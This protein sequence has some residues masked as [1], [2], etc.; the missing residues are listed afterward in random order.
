MLF[1]D[2]SAQFRSFSVLE[3]LEQRELGISITTVMRKGDNEE[4]EFGH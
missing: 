4:E 2:T 3:H 1:N